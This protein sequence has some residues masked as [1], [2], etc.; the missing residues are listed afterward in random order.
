MPDISQLLGGETAYFADVAVTEIM[1]ES[2][3]YFKVRDARGKAWNPRKVILPVG[4]ADS[5]PNIDG[6]EQLW[7]KRIYHCLFCHG[8]EDRDAVSTGILAVAPVGPT[9]AV[10]MAHSAAQLSDQVTIYTNGD[11]E[12]APELKPLMSSLVACKFSIEHAKSSVLLENW[13]AR[14]HH[15]VRAPSW[16][17]LGLATTPLSD[18]RAEAPP[19]QTSSPSVIAV[20][21]CSTPFKVVPSAI[22]SGCNAAVADSA[23]IQAAK[24]SQ[25]L[26]PWG[27]LGEEAY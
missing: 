8:Y 24:F 17:R 13:P 12:V 6:Y 10:H 18:I 21:D 1:K 25:A 16:L 4:S 20:G 22:T 26:G 5:Y 2:D 9:L 7:K 15:V 27:I 23:E 14:L 3:S 11:E 19:W